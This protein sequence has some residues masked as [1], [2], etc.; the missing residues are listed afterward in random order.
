M[1]KR[2]IFLVWLLV[3]GLLTGLLG[4]CGDAGAKT[5]QDSAPAQTAEP[6][7]TA[8]PEPDWA[9]AYT[10]AAEAAAGAEN[11]V[12]TGSM[13]EE[14]SIQGDT[15]REKKS[16]TARYQGRGTDGFAADIDQNV[17]VGNTRVNYRETFADGTAYLD[18]KS[19]LFRAETTAEEFMAIRIPETMFDPTLYGEITVRQ[20]DAGKELKFENPVK[21]EAWAAPETAELLSAAGTAVLSEEGTLLSER[22]E[23]SVRFV[24][25]T[26]TSTYEAALETPETMDLSDTVP[27]DKDA[28][29]E[30]KTF[31]AP[32]ILLRARAA[33][34]NASMLG[35]ELYEMTVSQAAGSAKAR[36]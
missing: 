28:Y 20:T 11:L 2:R 30:L 12:M 35:S 9:A 25:V 23:L 14:R 3:L 32:I 13:K 29:T 19:V 1:N 26:V 15:V 4:G 31:L 7:P 34:E 22:Y 17:Q 36:D 27:A 24:G 33:L 8:T 5:Q 21:A 16:F 10:E 18:V 6:E